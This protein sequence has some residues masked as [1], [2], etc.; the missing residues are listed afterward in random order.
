MSVSD[1]N[2]AWDK[3]DIL[4]FVNACGSYAL[5]PNIYVLLCDTRAFVPT[6]MFTNMTVVSL[7]FVSPRL[8]GIVTRDFISFPITQ[9][10]LIVI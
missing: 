2:L 1:I 6:E 8:S 4:Y 9:D 3:D 10:Y 7:N 5:Y